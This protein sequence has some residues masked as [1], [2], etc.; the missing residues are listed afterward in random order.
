MRSSIQPQRR[1]SALYRKYEDLLL[2]LKFEN[3]LDDSSYYDQQVTGFNP[4]VFTVAEKEIDEPTFDDTNYVVSPIDR[5]Y[6]TYFHGNVIDKY[7]ATFNTGENQTKQSI[8]VSG[9]GVFTADADDD[10]AE[11]LNIGP[12]QDFTFEFWAKHKAVPKGE[13]DNPGA[14]YFD[15]GSL[16]LTNTSGFFTVHTPG[17][18][19]WDYYSREFLLG[20]GEGQGR[21]G[22]TYYYKSVPNHVVSQNQACNWPERP[23]AVAGAWPGDLFSHTVT[24]DEGTISIDVNKQILIYSDFDGLS[25]GQATVSEIEIKIKK[26]G[27]TIQTIKD[28]PGTI[29]VDGTCNVFDCGG[30]HYIEVKKGDVISAISNQGEWWGFWFDVLEVGNDLGPNLTNTFT[31]Y[32]VQRRGDNVELWMGHKNLDGTDGPFKI[33][34]A[35]NDSQRE[36]P[37]RMNDF[38]V[39][40]LS[41]VEQDEGPTFKNW[42]TP[43]NDSRAIGSTISGTNFFSGWMDEFKVWGEAIYGP[44]IIFSEGPWAVGVYADLHASALIDMRSFA[45]NN[46]PVQPYPTNGRHYTKYFW[47]HST[48]VLYCKV[49][50]VYDER[51]SLH[52]P[53]P[54]TIEWYG[55]NAGFIGSSISSEYEPNTSAAGG[56]FLIGQRGFDE[57]TIVNFMKNDEDIYYAKVY[58]GDPNRPKYS[59]TTIPDGITPV[60]LKV[61]YRGIS[62]FSKGTKITLADKT[63]ENIESIKPGDKILSY[64][65]KEKIIEPDEVLSIS[66]TEAEET[67]ILVFDNGIENRNTL[68]HPY[69]TKEK[70]WASLSP[71]ETSL[72]HGMDIEKL[73]IGDT[74]YIHDENGE[75]KEVRLTAV[76]KKE[77]QITTYNLNKVKQNN[78]YFANKLLVH[79]KSPMPSL[80]WN[81]QCQGYK[82]APGTDV[83]LLAT[84]WSHPWRWQWPPISLLPTGPNTITWTNPGRGVQKDYNDAWA[85]ST[86]TFKNVRKSIKGPICAQLTDDLGVDWG[87]ACCHGISVD[88]PQIECPFIESVSPD[89][90]TNI[91]TVEPCRYLPSR[92]LCSNYGYNS[93]GNYQ[94]KLYSQI[95]VIDNQGTASLTQTYKVNAK[96]TNIPELETGGFEY[97]WSIYGWQEDAGASTVINQ[98][99]PTFGNNSSKSYT[100]LENFNGYVACEVKYKNYPSI[101]STPRWAYDPEGGYQYARSTIM[102]WYINFPE[103]Q[104]PTVYWHPITYNSTG[105]MHA[106][107]DRYG[108]YRG[109]SNQISLGKGKERATTEY[110]I[111]CPSC[112]SLTIPYSVLGNKGK[113]DYTRRWHWSYLTGKGFTK[114]VTYL[115]NIANMFLAV[116]DVVGYQRPYYQYQDKGET[117]F[118]FKSLYLNDNNTSLTI[119]AANDC[120]Q[121][122]IIYNFEVYKMPAAG[123]TT[124]ILQYLGTSWVSGGQHTWW[125]DSFK[126]IVNFYYQ[127]YDWY[128]WST[129]Q[130]EAYYREFPSS[131]QI[132]QLSISNISKG[133]AAYRIYINGQM[134]QN[135]R[136]FPVGTQT[137]KN[138][139][140]KVHDHSGPYS[141]YYWGWYGYYNR[142]WYSSLSHKLRL[143]FSKNKSL[144]GKD[145]NTVKID[146]VNNLPAA[147]QYDSGTISSYTYQ[148]NFNT[149][150]KIVSPT[151]YPRWG[152]WYCG[153]YYWGWWGYYRRAYWWWRPWCWWYNP[154]RSGGWIRKQT[155]FVRPDNNRVANMRQRTLFR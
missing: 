52:Q 12:N 37:Q 102:Y 13:D 152:W 97:Q 121:K 148:V 126:G 65:V 124:R 31:H 107:V 61:K 19:Q 26:N 50:T 47:E 39:T 96:D 75:L 6:T 133:C 2:W 125:Y 142:W 10:S 105:E 113:W 135:W 141:G 17:G 111:K 55:V 72:M 69:Y 112:T 95:K 129:G 51:Y 136:D 150:P 84:M 103:C 38:R 79:N 101:A 3:N 23:S 108:G 78:N 118:L 73:E 81:I 45:P 22:T 59:Y 43:Y 104:E 139:A 57:L 122:D 85:S 151:T 89:K 42:V 88:L 35:Y 70:G 20:I 74:C 115:G 18:A 53:L 144:W 155:S 140:L 146:V 7:S 67:S 63:E 138:G 116:A 98:K 16:K 49:A 9:S 93:Y 8:L 28:D 86:L 153:Y 134:V 131:D 71:K 30:V 119:R 114:N 76:Q 80:S 44:G 29:S 11:Y 127:E 82:I 21:Q 34:E 48:V 68:G 32:A 100:V 90:T 5:K 1:N 58:L 145:K 110:S 77:G 109:V 87:T 27:I 62:C 14:T 83:T 66:N 40:G 94:C 99:D 130:V 117:T 41:V 149:V 36:D 92:T 132:H 123:F 15:F 4:D 128:N 120:G 60:L 106:Y 64:N 154:S 46:K 147:G 56:K 91:F 143:T 33:V 24:V 54:Y 25:Q 137:Y